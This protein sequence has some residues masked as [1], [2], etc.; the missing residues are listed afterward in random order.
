MGFYDWRTKSLQYL[1]FKKIKFVMLANVEKQHVVFVFGFYSI[2]RWYSIGLQNGKN[3]VLYQRLKLRSILK[4][5]LLNLVPSVF[6]RKTSSLLGRIVDPFVHQMVYHYNFISVLVEKSFSFKL[7][8][9]GNLY[10]VNHNTLWFNL[11]TISY[12]FLYHF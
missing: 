1:R 3:L 8:I 7:K 6:W 12:H 5:H 9:F 11:K 4:P 2:F 10:L